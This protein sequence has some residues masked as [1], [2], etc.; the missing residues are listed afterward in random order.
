ME[1]TMVTAYG[2]SVLKNKHGPD[3]PLHGIGQ[4]WMDP[5]AGCNFGTGICT[6]CYDQLAHGFHIT[7]PTQTIVLQQNTRQFVDDNKLVHNGGRHTALAQELIIMVKEDVM[8]W[9]SILNTVSGLL[10][11]KK[12]AYTML[13]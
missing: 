3:N 1:Y 11:L 12:T 10:E 4:G 13:I 8:A 9:D 5:P 7:D 2:P 6:K